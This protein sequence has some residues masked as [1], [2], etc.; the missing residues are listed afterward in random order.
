M[1]FPMIVSDRVTA[2]EQ[3]YLSGDQ[4]S[5]VM[6]GEIFGSDFSTFAYERF[7]D[8]MKQQTDLVTAYATADPVLMF[9]PSLHSV[10][11]TAA[12][13]SSSGYD[14]RPKFARPLC[15]R[16]LDSR[17]QGV[18][19]LPIR[20]TPSHDDV[21]LNAL[22]ELLDVE[23]IQVAAET[24]RTAF[25]KPS[26]DPISKVIFYEIF[27]GD[28]IAPWVTPDGRL[29]GIALH[30]EDRV[31]VWTEAT[32]SVLDG[33]G[34]LIRGGPNPFGRIPGETFRVRKHPRS[35]WGVCDL[36]VVTLN[37]IAINKL[38][39]DLI[40]LAT[41]QSWA[42][43]VVYEDDEQGG[44][45]VPNEE[46]DQP[47]AGDQ[48]ARRQDM[49]W[50]SGKTVIVSKGSKVETLLPNANISAIADTVEIMGKRTLADAYVID[51][52]ES[53]AGQSGFSL[54]VRQ[55]PYLGKTRA[56]RSIFG[57]SLGR[58]LEFA[59]VVK[60]AAD[61][62]AEFVRP[63]QNSRGYKVEVAFDETPL[64]PKPVDEIVQL[65]QHE[66]QIGAQSTV[67]YVRESRSVSREEAIEI[68]TRVKEDAEAGLNGPEKK[69]SRNNDSDS[70]GD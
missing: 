50:S 66:R 13:E 42:I 2:F 60:F 47:I 25:V 9:E 19:A 32:F 33:D 64:I 31:E 27:R 26:W 43:Y 7:R 21:D 29:V 14:L 5:R 41:E 15:S 38:F 59:A 56:I 20:Y 67:D 68:V 46:T 70:D 53:Q 54:T 16:V 63:I 35:W 10:N 22:T 34:T 17:V 1:G 36:A 55:M 12:G 49:L 62:R 39:G 61:E 18:S 3:E 6:R 52:S 69:E 48:G 58:L 37:N 24:S 65:S 30:A 57:P 11:V 44:E 28:Q 8:R 45:Y 40:Q 23:K 51:V 4:I